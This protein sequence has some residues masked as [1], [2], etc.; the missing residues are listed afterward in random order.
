[1]SCTTH[2]QA[3]DCREIATTAL[4]RDLLAL[5]D[6]DQRA[7]PA[8]KPARYYAELLAEA[9]RMGYAVKDEQGDE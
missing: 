6:D 9:V 7:K 5:A 3:C 8:S 1:M 2:H 4:I